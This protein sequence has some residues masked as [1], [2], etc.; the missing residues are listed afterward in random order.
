MTACVLEQRSER[1]I[2]DHHCSQTEW[3]VGFMVS[4]TTGK[5]GGVEKLKTRLVRQQPS[6]STRDWGRPVLAFPLRSGMVLRA[7]ACLPVYPHEE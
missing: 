3:A 6:G 7:C 1:G 2:G 4:T 5:R